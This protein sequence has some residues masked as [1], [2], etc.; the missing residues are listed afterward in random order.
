MKQWITQRRAK[1]TIAVIASMLGLGSLLDLRADP[2]T[3]IRPVVRPIADESEV[4]MH[5]KLT[6]SKKVLEGLLRRDFDTIARAAREMKRISKETA[7]P[8]PQDDVYSHFST[9][10]QRQCNQL[11][12]HANQLNHDAAQFTFLHMTTT[13]IQCHEYI[14]DSRRMA[15]LKHPSNVRPIPSQWETHP[16]TGPAIK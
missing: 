13:C 7:W 1:L 10:F 9:E 12:S 2:P 5:A 11:E 14:R 16:K 6:S 4:L 3:A 15:G 8:R